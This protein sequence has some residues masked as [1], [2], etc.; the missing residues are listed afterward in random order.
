VSPHATLVIARHGESV[1][2]QTN[3]F[4]GWIDV[5]LSARGLAEARQAGASLREMGFVADVAFTSLLKRAIRTLWVILEETDLMWLPVHKS[6]RLNERHYGGLQGKNKAQ[7]AEA[8]GDE[9][10]HIWRRSYAVRPPQL[11]EDSEMHPARDRRYHGL[12]IDV[13]ALPL[14]ESLQDTERR[15]LPYWEAEIA[16]RL[17]TGK[18][19]L[20]AAHGNS[21]RALVKHLEQ[22]GDDDIAGVNIPTGRPKVYEFDADL[23]PLRTFYQSEPTSADA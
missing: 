18:N 3:V 17:R 11:S 16:P 7:T 22:V 9:Q 1:W 19:V 2:N 21:L 4:T 15:V 5:D 13:E 14:G 6:W 12:D 8:F 10:V 20:V 23:T